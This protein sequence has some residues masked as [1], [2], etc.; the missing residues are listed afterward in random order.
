MTGRVPFG[1]IVGVFDFRMRGRNPILVCD[2]LPRRPLSATLHR[3]MPSIH[4]DPAAL[5]AL[6]DAIY[7]DK[8]LRARRM[9]EQER[10][11][12]GVELSNSMILR[13][14]DGAMWQLNL[15]DPEAGWREVRRRLQR[16]GQVHDQGR[17]S[18]Q[19]PSKS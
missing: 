14:H 3:S 17:Y 18:N 4:D 13:L 1:R 11:A 5:K 6:Q 19:R 8:V 16:L 7:R 10:F 15:S 9:T 2:Q 12:E